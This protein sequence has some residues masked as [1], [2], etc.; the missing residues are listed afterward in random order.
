MKR[1]AVTA[2]FATLIL[3][4]WS[5]SV[6]ADMNLS[7]IEN[8]GD[9]TRFLQILYD[10]IDFHDWYNNGDIEHHPASS[11][12]HLNQINYDDGFV[13]GQ[14]SSYY[15]YE[16][17]DNGFT[18]NLILDCWGKNLQSVESFQYY[19]SANSMMHSG[20]SIDV[21][22]WEKALLKVEITGATWDGTDQYF[23]L[24][25][26]DYQTY[27][28]LEFNYDGKYYTTFLDSGVYRMNSWLDSGPLIN[29][30]LTKNVQ[31]NVSFEVVPVPGAVLLGLI[32]LGYS[33]LRLRRKTE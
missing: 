31:I 23:S 7:L 33:G 3:C 12:S 24:S 30:D 29:T 10:N 25:F 13:S 5:N 20:W 32:G 27:L 26:Q 15:S 18:V 11:C 9:T 6:F 1:Q 19:S 8:T 14:A 28:P 4:F 17:E 21:E 2:F 16:I 22:P